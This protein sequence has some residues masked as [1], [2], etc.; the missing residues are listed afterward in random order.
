MGVITH[1]TCSDEYLK[2]LQVDAVK[3]IK[4][5]KN[6]KDIDQAKLKEYASLKTKGLKTFSKS[7]V[8]GARRWSGR[9]QQPGRPCRPRPS[10]RSWGRTKRPM[11]VDFPP[12]GEPWAELTRF[13]PAVLVFQPERAE[14]VGSVKGLGMRKR[15]GM[16]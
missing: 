2:V 15:V 12:C 7:S 11:E 9:E 10:V 13:G 4:T 3:T 16:F 5:V 14:L 8:C 6:N 1:F